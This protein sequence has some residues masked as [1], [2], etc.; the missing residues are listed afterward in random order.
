MQSCLPY[1]CNT[2]EDADLQK[3]TR[4]F[5]FLAPDWLNPKNEG[6]SVILFVVGR[7]RRQW[8]YINVEDSFAQAIKNG[9]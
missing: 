6:V 8:R 5:W 7:E 4:F 3:C 1:F 2:V 9:L